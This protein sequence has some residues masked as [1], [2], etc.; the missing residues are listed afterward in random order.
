MQNQWETTDLELSFRK[1]PHQERIPII[2]HVR[3]TEFKSPNTVSSE[4]R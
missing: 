3:F 2:L 1:E 4:F